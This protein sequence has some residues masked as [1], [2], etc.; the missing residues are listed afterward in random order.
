MICACRFVLTRTAISFAGMPRGRL[1]LFSKIRRDISPATASAIR[2]TA[3]LLFNGLDMSIFLFAPKYHKV[4]AG[5]DFSFIDLIFSP[6]IPF[7]NPILSK[8]NG[9][10]IFE[11]MVF[12]AV[13]KLGFDRQFFIKVYFEFVFRAAFI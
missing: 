5:K 4:N 9:S 7:S 6:D 1:F 13:I 3:S 2:G 11:N 8:T 12:T 10:F